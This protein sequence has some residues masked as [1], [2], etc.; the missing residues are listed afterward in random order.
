MRGQIISERALHHYLLSDKQ[1]GHSITLFLPVLH[2]WRKKADMGAGG[3]NLVWDRVCV[4][5]LR[6]CV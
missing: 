1:L 4:C 5:A 3:E 6:F 2:Q